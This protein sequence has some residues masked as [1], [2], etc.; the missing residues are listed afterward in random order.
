MLEARCGVDGTLKIIPAEPGDSSQ[1][2]ISYRN[3]TRLPEDDLK[4]GMRVS[5]LKPSKLYASQP[6]IDINKL[7]TA[8]A[9]FSQLEEETTLVIPLFVHKIR[10]PD[11]NSHRIMV[12]GDCHHRTLVWDARG[13][14]IEG[15]IIATSLPDRLR[16]TSLM[17]FSQFRRL[18][19]S[20]V[21][22]L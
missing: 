10:L 5:P 6:W 8:L 2:K 9:L 17:P 20:E 1:T 3:F 11:G 21:I 18:Y 22:N 12:I 13:L 4:I 14:R 15:E 19:A 7:R 16:N